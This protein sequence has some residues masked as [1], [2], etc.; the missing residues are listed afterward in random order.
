MAKQEQ[1]YANRLPR[2][3]VVQIDYCAIMNGREGIAVEF[4]DGSRKAVHAP[5]G[6]DH[7]VL[8]DGLLKFVNAPN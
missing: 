2:P 1:G 3:G 7:D 6:T 4:E 5:L 8:F